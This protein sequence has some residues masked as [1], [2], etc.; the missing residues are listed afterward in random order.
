MVFIRADANEQIGTGHVM[1]CL[2][3]ARELLNIGEE[4]L[5]VTADNRGDILI[6]QAGLRSICMQSDW[7]D[8][9]S[10]LN[11]LRNYIVQYKP[12]LVLID[13]YYVTENYFKKLHGLSTLA[14]IDDLNT[15]CWKVDLLLNYNIFATVFDYSLYWNTNTKLLLGPRYVPLREEF[16]SLIFCEK[17]DKV[18]NIMVS[19]GGAD[20]ERVT[21]KIM[22]YICT[23]KEFE[24]TIIH[25]VVGALNPRLETIKDKAR[26]VKNAVLHINEHHMADLMQNCDIA[27]AAAG[28][29]LYELCACGLP[30]ITYTLADNQLVAAEE[31]Q[32]QGIM[33]NAGD[34]RR[35]SRFFDTLK[36]HL[37]DIIGD[38]EK[39]REMSQR[40]RMCVDGKGVSRIV[41]ELICSSTAIK[42]EI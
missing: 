8:M 27:V 10:E 42:W 35:N 16:Q 3:I 31:F 12:R 1:R 30:T 18:K 25:F 7:T 22:E 9:E 11:D 40:M 6:Q 34:C 41:E 4:V 39:R 26:S 32:K 24:N 19:A 33:I 5:F 15:V 38:S 14:Y 36:Y 21:E 20:P 29:T 23:E 17:R 13:S 2:A 28:T 37:R